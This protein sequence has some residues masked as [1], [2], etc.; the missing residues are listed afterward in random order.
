MCMFCL[1]ICM[2]TMYVSGAHGGQKKAVGFPRTGVWMVVSH[3]MVA[4][5]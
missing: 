2:C 3:N 5:N 1:H 4:R